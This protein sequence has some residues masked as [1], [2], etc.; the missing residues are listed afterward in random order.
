M[1]I[2]KQQRL[3]ESRKLAKLL[4]LKV[5]L[6]KP[7]DAHKYYLKGKNYS[8]GFHTYSMLY[9]NLLSGYIESTLNSQHISNTI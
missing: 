3:A 2:T 5:V 7:E 8:M 4:G 9:E 6:G 1:I